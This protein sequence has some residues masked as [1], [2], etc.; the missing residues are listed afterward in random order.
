[1]TGIEKKTSAPT[2]DMNAAEKSG[3][4]LDWF[5]LA[6]LYGWA[7]GNPPLFPP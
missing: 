5:S 6:C 7:G 2:D 1:M 3:Y 4:Y